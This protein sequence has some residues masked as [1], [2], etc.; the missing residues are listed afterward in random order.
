MYTNVKVNISVGQKEKL[1]RALA[2]GTQLS[3]HLSHSDLA[4]E[5]TIAV[6]NSISLL[7]AYPPC[8]P[9]S[10]V[11][12]LHLTAIN[13]KPSCLARVNG[14]VPSRR[15]SLSALLDAQYPEIR[16]Y[17]YLRPSLFLVLPWTARSP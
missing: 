11:M 17:C 6:L 15:S 1:K 10:R 7:P 16:L 4:G 13:Q 3:L 8:T 14:Y 2:T 5:H 12:A 9:G